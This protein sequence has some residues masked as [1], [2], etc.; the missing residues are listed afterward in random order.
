MLIYA[1]LS[2]IDDNPFQQRQEYGDIAE[3]AGD[4]LRHKTT[5]PDTLGLQ[6]VPAARLVGDD[7]DL[8]PAS[9]L[10]REDWLTDSGHLLPGW[11][12]QMEFGHRRKRAFEYLAN[13]GAY[14]FAKMPLNILD[15]SDDDMLDGVW[16]ENA[17]RKDISAVEE[18]ELIRLKLERMG[19]GATHADIGNEWGLSRPVISNR[20]R[21]LE[22]PEE[23]QAANRDGRLSERQALALKPIV[24][25]DQ[26]VNG[27]VEWGDRID[28]T[29]G[30]PAGADKVIAAVL[31]KPEEFTSDALRNHAKKM[32]E[33]AGRIL[34]D[35][36]ARHDY[37]KMPGIEQPQCKG[38]KFRIDQRCLDTACLAHKRE[39][40]AEIAVEQFSQES[41]IPI[42]DR[43]EDF[44]SHYDTAKHIRAL[45]EAGITD[46]MVCTWSEE[47]PA[48]RASTDYVHHYEFFDE[49]GR[50]G[51]AL[52][53]RGELPPLPAGKSGGEGGAPPRYDVPPPDVIRAWENE[54]AKIAST[55]KRSL[56]TAVAD[57]LSYQVA[58][59]DLIQFFMNKEDAEWVYESSKVA[60]QFAEFL[61]NKGARVT[62]YQ[63]F[64]SEVQAYQAMANKLGMQ[65]NVLGD[66][67]EAARKT[68]VLILGHWYSRHNGWN[69]EKFA[70]DTLAHIAEW[71]QQPGTAA[72][73]MAEHIARAKRHIE[74][75]IAAEGEAAKNA[76]RERLEKETAV[77]CQ[78]CNK[79]PANVTGEPYCD[80]CWQGELTDMLRCPSCNAGSTL[81][82]SNTG[83]T[84]EECWSCHQ[85]FSMDEWRGVKT[86]VAEPAA[87]LTMSELA[88]A[89]LRSYVDD[90]GRTW[91]D[92]E[93]NQT[94]HANSPC[95]QAFTRAFPDEAEPKW[96]LK[97]ARAVLEQEVAVMQEVSA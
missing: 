88:V 24:E 20:L 95:F 3:L 72:S 18:A 43:A 79:R 94:H 57:A 83:E 21:L 96:Q 16:S 86:A 73:P 55:A 31:A 70:H 29:W 59:F 22:L 81:P 84:E 10:D 17:K 62:W 87:E 54:Q 78:H 75:K 42:S 1:P 92:L 60:K 44:S 71:E 66:K 58:E 19:P 89:W 30:M 8:V 91:R 49:D 6:Q 85:T 64:L 45:Y 26:L 56:L 41:G 35:C 74:E 28:S 76:E 50:G 4:I 48:A 33:N 82:K 97:Q 34:P 32:V 67:L 47:R 38:C 40:W 63:T 52:G 12:V 80:K 23:V 65:I 77:T 69:W 93:P 39:L 36:I 37:G 68:A 46:G 90:T 7:G 15:L 14:E 13:N 25:I 2:Q 27:R 5:R 51:I 9:G 53:W 11:R 61:F